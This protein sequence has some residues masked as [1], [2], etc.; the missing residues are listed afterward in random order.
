MTKVA[1]AAVQCTKTKG[2][3][4]QKVFDCVDAVIPGLSILLHWES[5]GHPTHRPASSEDGS[6]NSTFM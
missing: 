5:L 2:E 6:E 1:L 3:E 4:C